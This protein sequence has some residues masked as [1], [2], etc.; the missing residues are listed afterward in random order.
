[1]C[2]TRAGFA[3]RRAR[4]TAGVFLLERA[5]VRAA[6]RRLGRLLRAFDRP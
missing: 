3:V 6:R 2:V 4:L 5:D 1:M